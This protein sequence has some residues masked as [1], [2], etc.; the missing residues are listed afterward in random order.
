MPLAHM[1]EDRHQM[2]RTVRGEVTD[3]SE[4][5]GYKLGSVYIRKV[6]FRDPEMIRQIEAKVVNRLRQVTSAIKQDGANQVSII[7]S[8]AE[9][10]AAVE[11]AK[12]AAIRPYI[13]GMVLHDISTDQEIHDA[14][15]EI[16]EQQKLLDHNV[17]VTMVPENRGTLTDLIG[18]K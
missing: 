16:L 8:T 14:M 9:R 5:W 11:F 7:T 13:V 12:A 10:E 18:A 17:P 2:S 3:K 1:L 15:F 6:H 4:E